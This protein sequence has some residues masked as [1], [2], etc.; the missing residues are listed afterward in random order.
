MRGDGASSPMT[1][2]N[3]RPV[4]LALLLSV[5]LPGCVVPGED[6]AE[7]RAVRSI[8]GAAPDEAGAVDLV[9]GA[10]IDITRDASALTVALDARPQVAG[11]GVSGSDGG[12]AEVRFGDVNATDAVWRWRADEAR[13]QVSQPV[14]VIG[15]VTATSHVGTTTP[16]ALPDGTLVTVS[17]AATEG[18]E[19]T[20]FARGSSRLRAG[21]AHVDLPT[22][23]VALV[24][25]GPMTVQV[26]LT[27]PGPALYVG[28]KS[29]DRIVV[30]AVD[31]SD[32]TSSF[33][34]FV[35]ATRKGGETFS[36]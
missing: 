26:T 8:A 21:I 30:Q 22:A 17:T 35:Q 4:L 14:Q 27:S 20:V 15:A 28:E 7:P 34:W 11:L 33:D 16:L 24:G 6:G 36:P 10:G 32:A 9:A 29:P 1:E 31:G 18:A 23:F 5:A 2:S 13:F 25:E 12:D 3:I 19:S